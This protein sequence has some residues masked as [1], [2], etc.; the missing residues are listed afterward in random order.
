MAPFQKPS[1]GGGGDTP[2]PS[3]LWSLDLGAVDFK[4]PTVNF[5]LRHHAG[6]A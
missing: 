6:S 1:P 5:W 2:T 3:K 4:P